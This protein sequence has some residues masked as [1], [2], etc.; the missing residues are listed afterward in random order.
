MTADSFKSSAGLYNA[1]LHCSRLLVAVS[2]TGG[3]FMM[4]AAL[5]HS[6]VSQHGTATASASGSRWRL[7][8][9]LLIDCQYSECLGRMGEK[10]DTFLWGVIYQALTWQTSSSAGMLLNSQHPSQNAPAVTHS[11]GVAP[12]WETSE[13]MKVRRLVLVPAWCL[14]LVWVPVWGWGCWG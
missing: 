7:T 11:R 6:T 2:K 13:Y 9:H 1:M 3:D 8:R 14:L 5:L 4:G 12:T 10:R